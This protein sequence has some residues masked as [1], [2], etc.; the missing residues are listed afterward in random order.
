MSIIIMLSLVVQLFVVLPGWYKSVF[1][2]DLYEGL[3]IAQRGRLEDQRGTEIKFE[4]PEFLKRTV[5]S[6][7]LKIK[8]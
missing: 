4:M 3:K 1:F 5:V 8:G 2:P 7:N 6:F